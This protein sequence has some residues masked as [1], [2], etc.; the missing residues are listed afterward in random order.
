MVAEAEAERDQSRSREGSIA[1]TLRWRDAWVRKEKREK[2]K[3]GDYIHADVLYRKLEPYVMSID[4]DAELE[5]VQGHAHGS[6]FGLLSK[7][8]NIY[9]ITENML[10]KT[11]STV[12][13]MLQHAFGTIF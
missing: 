9:R 1:G 2:S 13:I 11:T 7:C 6:E 8:L 4:A 3:D 5:R 12:G 10:A